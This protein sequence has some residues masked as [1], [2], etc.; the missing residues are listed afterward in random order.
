MLYTSKR[1]SN[2]GGPTVAEAKE[3]YEKAIASAPTELN[4]YVRLANL[5]NDKPADLKITKDEDLRA[6]ADAKI[7]AMVNA[8]PENHQAYLI[9]A[10]YRQKEYTVSPT[11]RDRRSI[12]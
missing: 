7:T 2:L 5:L 12:S 4:N 8:N 10:R 1:L 9:R 11:D 3:Y 6:L